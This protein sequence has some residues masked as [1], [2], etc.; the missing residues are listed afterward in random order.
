M[1]NPPAGHSRARDILLNTLTSYLRDAVDI[2]SFIVLV[3]FLIKTLGTESFGL[4]SLLWSFIS[5]FSLIDMGVGSSVVKYVGEAKGKGNINRQQQVISTIFWIYL[6]LGT[7]LMIAVLPCLLFFNEVFDIPLQ[8]QGSAKT[9]LLILGVRSALGVPLDLF[10]GLLISF[11][12]YRV[13]NMYR[14][15]AT[16][17][18]FGSV[19]IILPD[20]S[21][22]WVLALLNLLMGV[23]PRVVMM[24]H[25]KVSLPGITLHPRYFQRSI[26]KE[27]F[28][29]SIYFMIIRVSGLIYTRVD[30]LIIKAY[31]PLEMVAIY[32]IAMRLSD[33]G[34]RFCAQL[35]R[36]LT[37]VVAEL[38][39][40]D[41]QEKIKEVWYQGAKLTIAMATPL[42]LGLALLGEPLVRAWTGEEF[43]SAV[44]VLYWLTSAAMVGIIHGNTH[45]ILSMGGEQRYLAFA[46]LASQVLNVILSILLITPLG[47]IGVGMA[48]LCS[49]LPVEVL[50]IQRKACKMYQSTLWGFYKR[51]VFPMI[52]SALIMV[53]ALT[54]IQSWWKIDTMVEVA[55]GEFIAI[56]LFGLS[57]WWIGF[58]SNERR[59]FMDK[60]LKRLRR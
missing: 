23:V 47:I 50:L 37:P 57:Y 8:Q 6:G 13:A 58:N 30:A 14:M 11:Q 46:L 52:P 55:G 45:N 60:G 9:V 21:K 38:Q 56:G 42:L 39:G 48:T 33:T 59:Y 35:N 41:D 29:F 53:G 49:T 12:R 4:W 25:A 15:I 54:I 24:I 36:V 27:I 1:S 22:L 43:I 40:A 16:I 32:A 2:L 31:L 19:L 17:A 18:Y 10:R 28:S 34:E 44:P 3:P 5:L 7:V 20:I 26:V 51:T